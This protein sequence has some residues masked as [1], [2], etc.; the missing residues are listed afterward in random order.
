[1]YRD[2]FRIRPYGDNGDDWLHLGERYAKNPIGAG[3]RKGGYHVRQNQ[4]VGVVEISRFDSL[5]LQD[6]S[7]REGLQE[8]YVFDL[9]K[10]ILCGIINIMEVDRNT[11]MYNLSLLY[12]NNNPRDIIKE[13]YRKIP[14]TARDLRPKKYPW[15]LALFEAY[16]HILQGSQ[17]FVTV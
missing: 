9:F 13:K 16:A 2:N 15:H 10:D 4:V 8:T 7:G 12:E 17:N 6:K 11:I 5:Y 3:Q 1:M 14:S